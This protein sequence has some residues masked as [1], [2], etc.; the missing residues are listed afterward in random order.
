MSRYFAQRQRGV[1]LIE[2]MVAMVLGL[3]V[4]AGIITVFLSTSSSN[5]AQT[6]MAR[7]QE[8]GRYAVTRLK[9]DLRM[10]NGQYC[11][12]SGG[13]AHPSAAQTFMDGLRAPTVYARNVTAAM[14]D[15]TTTMG[16]G[17]Y[18][19]VP[20]GSYYM[21]SFLSMRGYD[22]D[23]SGCKPVDP[24][25][26]VS[27]IPKMGKTAGSRVIGADVLTVRYM[28]STGGWPI[29]GSNTITAKADGT[30]ASIHI[31]PA[32][33]E[34]ALSTLKG[35]LAMLADCSNAE[36]FAVSDPNSS[37]DFS[38]AS[39]S[40]SSDLNLAQP[41]VQQPQSAPRLF[42]FNDDYQTVTYYLQV[43]DNGNGS[44]QTTGALMRRVNG[45]S[46]ELV[47]GVER[48][49]F[50][51]GVEGADGKLKYLAADK[52]DASSSADC[53]PS[54]PTPLGTD[55]GCLWRAVKSIEINLVMDGQ[56][57]LASLASTDLYYTYGIDK[58]TTPKAPAD[59]PIK[60]SDQG[61][62]DGMIRR[63]FTYLVSVRNYNP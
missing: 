11:T 3:L 59:H 31:V 41:I 44:G 34:P 48:L 28:N 23:K 63:E 47:R 54:V 32:T 9:D 53:P 6:Q 61:F 30:I 50:R 39:S 37:G 29:G 58:I 16:S 33:G 2:L 22:C 35:K 17:S 38:P 56:L 46:S 4:S 7:L 36:I 20:T 24:N 27:A 52:V 45:T 8:E 42:N 49:D 15:V 25:S 18:P 21:P 5:R 10:A 57:P 26:A 51:Y 40:S 55:P 12:N 60:P 14:A 19:A 43:V 62:P 13:V 1:T